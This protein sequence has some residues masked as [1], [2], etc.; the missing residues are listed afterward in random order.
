[1]N[2]IQELIRGERFAQSEIDDILVECYK[3][4]E[5]FAKIFFPE[6]CSNAFASSHREFFDAWDNSDAQ[7]INLIA[8]RGWGKSTIANLIIPAKDLV[9]RD[10]HFLLQLANT[11]AQAERDSEDLKTEL[12]TNEHLLTVFG[13]V[14]PERRDSQFSKEAW[15]TPEKLSPEGKIEHLGTLIM[16]RGWG[17][18]VR[19][20]KNGRF[21][22]D[23]LVCDDI[24][25][26][27]GAMSEE[28]RTK[29]KGWVY[30]DLLNVVQR[31]QKLSAGEARHRVLFIGTLLHQDSLLANL[32]EN[33]DWLTITAPLCELK[34]D[35]TEVLTL[36]SDFMSDKAVT[37]L[38]DSL[39]LA[40]EIDKF[41][42]EYLCIPVPPGVSDFR[43][44]KYYNPYILADIKNLESVVIVDP[45]KVAGARNCDS[46]IVG[47]S[48]DTFGNRLFLRDVIKGQIFNDDL[49]AMAAEMAKAIGAKTIGVESSGLGAFVIQ[50]FEDFLRK[51]G[52]NFELIELKSPPKDD[53]KNKRIFSLLPYYRR[54]CVYHNASC[55]ATLEAQL[56]G[57]IYSKKKDVAD[58]AAYVV[59]LMHLGDRG[60]LPDIPDVHE[61]DGK[62]ED[63]IEETDQFAELER[64]YIPAE[65]SGEPASLRLGAYPMH[66]Y[67]KSLHDPF[68]PY[69]VKKS[70]SLHT[71]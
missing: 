6:R 63:M 14:R 42:R 65:S 59:Q 67:R 32:A 50:P 12:M 55:C 68:N 1:M 45:A 2:A 62:P 28:Q 66:V 60:F 52:Y 8:H 46:A 5:L 38:R 26:T 49:Y 31:S 7:L 58:A 34:E 71:G 54:G 11:S 4:T 27:E 3:S 69:G 25:G 70:A 24:E 10:I 43:P 39:E 29:L 13:N 16:P 57:G 36:W 64:L 21:R 30:A 9:Y 15:K 33:K 20:L 23:R 51:W 53:A 22:P 35:R 41:Y 18:Q 44:Y 19:G 48:L 17:Q 61:Y 37:K 56:D 40:G 47:W